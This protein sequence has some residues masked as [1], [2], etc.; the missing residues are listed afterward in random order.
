MALFMEHDL[1]E[2]NCAIV[3]LP[4]NDVQAMILY[5]MAACEAT[6]FIFLVPYLFLRIPKMFAPKR[7][8]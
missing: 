8:S 1:Y 7:K 2:I 5:L 3:G 6:L 4:A